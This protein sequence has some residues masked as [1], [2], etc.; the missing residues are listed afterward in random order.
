ME[1]NMKENMKERKKKSKRGNKRLP[2]KLQKTE[3]ICS[4]RVIIEGHEVVPSTIQ[5]DIAGTLL[6]VSFLIMFI[7]KLLKLVKLKT[8]RILFTYVVYE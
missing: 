4:E 7:N 3:P 8:S 6:F 5:Q 1:E 2:L